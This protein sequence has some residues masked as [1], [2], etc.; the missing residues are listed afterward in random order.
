M[1]V[2]I[3]SFVVFIVAA[4]LAFYTAKKNQGLPIISWS[5]LAIAFIYG[6]GSSIVFVA[7][8][9]NVSYLR[10][11]IVLNNMLYWPFYGP[12]AL[13]L[14]IGIFLGW[15]LP[16]IGKKHI[17]KVSRYS[18]DISFRKMLWIAYTLLII[19]IFSP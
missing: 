16:I 6:V 9:D 7:T 1:I 3:N 18:F 19:G 14:T 4:F 13:M 17:N 8:S 5:F 15:K 11:D 2:I 10:S 12:L